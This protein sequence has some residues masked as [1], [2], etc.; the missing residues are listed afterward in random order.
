MNKKSINR[1]IFFRGVF[2]ILLFMVLLI[3]AAQLIIPDREYSEMENRNLQTR[4]EISLNRILSGRYSTDMETYVS[5]QFPM[6]T[7]WIQLKEIA[8]RFLGKT[9][10]NNIFLS[11]DGYLMEDFM[12]ADSEHY[13]LQI[14]CL[15]KFAEKEKQ[16]KQ[17]ML[18][19]PTAVNIYHELLP[20]FAQTGD[21]NSF[22]DRLKEDVEKIGITFVDVRNTFCGA[23]NTQLYYKT[24]HHWTTDAAYLAWKQFAQTAELKESDVGYQ[25]LLVTDSFSGT[26]SASSGFRMWEKEGIYI[27]LPENSS[28]EYSVEYVSEARKSASFY[29]ADQLKVRD[30]YAVF[31]G[32]NHPLVR[33]STTA[34][35]GKVMLIFKDS[36]ANCF[37]PFM[38]EN[39]DKI[40]MVDPRYYYDDPE[41]LISS[42]GVTDVLYLYNAN[43]FAEDTSLISVLGGEDGEQGN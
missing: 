14:N 24:D 43:G 2:I 33:I 31:L 38:I 25:R 10:S 3:R 4:P 29:E 13:A 40:L 20:A 26:M 15:K 7:G 19:V 39:Y 36:Y 35:T 30:K 23:E 42:E 5:D 21:Q 27:Y 17:Y 11:D 28:V 32:G 41:K 22:L 34:K 1:Q 16:L 12:E 37:V 6:R 8:D 18:A 9:E